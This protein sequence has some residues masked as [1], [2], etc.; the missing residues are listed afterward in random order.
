MSTQYVTIGGKEVDLT[1]GGPAHRKSPAATT[2]TLE[3]ERQTTAR[4]GLTA[5]IVG[6]LAA[7]GL[8]IVV[9]VWLSRQRRPS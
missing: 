1:P 3:Q 6:L 4:S 5:T 2:A 9:I 8:L 7:L